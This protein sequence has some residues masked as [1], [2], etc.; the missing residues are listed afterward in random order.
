M[1]CMGWK[2]FSTVYVQIAFGK[3]FILK[4]KNHAKN[5][6]F[7]HKL[8]VVSNQLICALYRAGQYHACCM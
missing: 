2:A 1:L 5:L 6:D 4:S 8:N 7:N 3:P